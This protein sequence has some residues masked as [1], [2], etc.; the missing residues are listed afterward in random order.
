MIIGLS[1]RITEHPNS[2][3]SFCANRQTAQYTTYD[4]DRCKRLSEKYSRCFAGFYA[5]AW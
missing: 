4:N 1:R 5:A 3:S 2:T